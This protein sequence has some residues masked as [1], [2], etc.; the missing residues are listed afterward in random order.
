MGE[1]GASARA[2]RVDGGRSLKMHARTGGGEKAQT[3]WHDLTCG[4]QCVGRVLSVHR[5][6]GKLLTSLLLLRRVQGAAA[7]ADKLSVGGKLVTLPKGGKTGKPIK[8]V[9]PKPVKHNM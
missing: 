9:E 4:P 5:E 8:P 3:I 1:L 7:G 6:V 2:E